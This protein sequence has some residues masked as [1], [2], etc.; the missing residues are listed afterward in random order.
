MTAQ[1][2]AMVEQQLGTVRN[3]VLLLDLKSNKTYTLKVTGAPQQ[4]KGDQGDNGSWTQSGNTI[5]F[6][7]AKNKTEKAQTIKVAPN[8]KSMTLIAPGGQ[9]KVVFTR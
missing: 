5:T 1:Q 2:K 8:G 3:I 4:P 7:S 6:K 9:G